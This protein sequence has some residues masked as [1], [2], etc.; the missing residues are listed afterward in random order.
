MTEAITNLLED[1]NRDFQTTLDKGLEIEEYNYT[2]NKYN[3]YDVDVVFNYDNGSLE[4]LVIYLDNGLLKT[5]IELQREVAACCLSFCK[6]MK[7]LDNE[8]SNRAEEDRFK[9]EQYKTSQL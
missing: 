8:E 4:D 7:E 9:N 5:P 3:G 2:Y 1:L 6:S